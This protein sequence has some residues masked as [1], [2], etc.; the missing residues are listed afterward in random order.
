MPDPTP[1]EPLEADPPPW[2]LRHIFR[3]YRGR[4][5]LTYALFN[6]ENLLRLAEPFVLGLAI[7]G[8]LHGSYTGLV[9]L[10]IQHLAHLLVGTA[11]R[12][13][14]TRIFTKVYADL[15]SQL[16]VEQRERQVEVSR[17][18]ARSALSRSFVDFFER[19][20]PL[21]LWALYSLIGGLAMLLFYDWM[22]VPFCLALCLPVILLNFRYARQTLFLS[23]GLHDELEREVNIIQSGS[24]QEVEAHY[25]RVAR[26]RIRL[27]DR[28]AM[29][30]S[31]TELFVLGL[32]IAALI[33]VASL[34]LEPGDIF[35]VF[36][37]VLMF[38]MGL[39]MVPALV[40]Q[41]SRLRDIGR[42]LRSQDTET[43][44]P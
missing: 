15:A 19:D 32:I 35:A 23:G 9:I 1:P 17:V 2:A 13:Y 27:S 43:M 42:R 16:V 4:L 24:R 7:N 29:N 41:I 38:I 22:L 3:T 21:S 11:R 12:I 37:Y 5:L 6:L 36:R 18:A 28:E 44:R 31:Y 33:R 40:E 34:G 14:D 20:V 8:L 39:D 10:I 26:W 30:F 25:G